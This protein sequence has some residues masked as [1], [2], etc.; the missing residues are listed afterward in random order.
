MGQPE[1]GLRGSLDAIDTV[2]SHVFDSSR[3]EDVWS[4]GPLRSFLRLK[5]QRGFAKSRS[6][7]VVVREPH[8]PII[9]RQTGTMD[10]DDIFGMDTY[11]ESTTA[12]PDS[13]QCRSLVT[14]REPRFLDS[15]ALFKDG[16]RDRVLSL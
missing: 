10:R 16:F 13:C 1:S 14:W 5:R 8:I 9:R 11:G 7:G 6:P 3:T 4:S 15:E 2:T 12:Q